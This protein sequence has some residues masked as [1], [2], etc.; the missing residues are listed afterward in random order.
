[1]RTSLL[2]LAA[3][4]CFALLP[5]A[6]AAKPDCTDVSGWNAGREGKSADSACTAD[7]YAEA[8]RLGEALADLVMRR[9]A[10]DKRI[11]Q[12]PDDVGALRRHQRQIDVDIEAIHGVAMLRGWPTNRPEGEAP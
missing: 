2:P 11:A 1:M 12:S 8:F 3:T 5:L 7:A 10:L 9:A 4:L 6:C